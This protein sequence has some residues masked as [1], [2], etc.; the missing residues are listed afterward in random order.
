[1]VDEV[2]DEVVVLVGVGLLAVNVNID[3]RRAS[4]TVDARTA[5][6]PHPPRP[7]SHLHH[8]YHQVHEIPLYTYRRRRTPPPRPHAIPLRIHT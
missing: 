7:L 3:E 5:P 8:H 2:V 6:L 4:N 1:M